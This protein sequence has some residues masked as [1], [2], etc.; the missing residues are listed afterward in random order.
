MSYENHSVVIEAAEKIA[1]ADWRYHNIES[2]DV[3]QKLLGTIIADAVAKVREEWEAERWYVID[4]NQD[5]RVV[6]GPFLHEETASEVRAYL[7]RE[8]P[9]ADWNLWIIEQAALNPKVTP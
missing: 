6:V 3:V 1:G 9:N 4:H 7:E 8:S 2:R 5:N